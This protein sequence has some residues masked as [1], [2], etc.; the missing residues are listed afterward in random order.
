MTRTR[1]HVLTHSERQCWRNCH[2]LHGYAYVERLR[3]QRAHVALRW[4]IMFHRVVALATVAVYEELP[5]RRAMSAGERTYCV[6]SAVDW[7]R[8]Y[9][10]RTLAELR[11]ELAELGDV[12]AR[13][14]MLGELE[15]NEPWFS[16]A[17]QN[18]FEL[19]GDDWSEYELLGVEVP[20]QVRL[21]DSIGRV[22]PTMVHEG[23]MDILRVHVPT[24]RVDVSDHKTM[25]TFT[26]SERRLQL[27]D[28]TTGYL[29]AARELHR[30][31]K[32]PSFSLLAPHLTD[33]SFSSVTHNLSRKA[34]PSEP[35]VNKIKKNDQA[36]AE[37]FARLKAEEETTGHSRG[38]VSTAACDTT[39]GRY[40]AALE[41]QWTARGIPVD[42]DQRAFLRTLD[43]R[44]ETFFRRVQS[45]RS[46]H[47]LRRW[48][49]EYMVEQHHIRAARA[50]ELQ[51]TRNPGHCT[52][53][54]SASC[55]YQ[56]ICEAGEPASSRAGLV[57]GFVRVDDPHE[58]V[59]RG[60]E[61]EERR[62]REER[63]GRREALEQQRRDQAEARSAG[64]GDGERQE[65]RPRE[66]PG[67]RAP[68][69]AAQ[70]AD[71]DAGGGSG[72]GEPDGD[73]SAQADHR[74]F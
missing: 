26:N 2:A 49:S 28:Q 9:V 15:E 34:A 43:G 6:N 50:D 7:T 33:A 19:T 10:A 22:V 71:P 41:V 39:A 12:D 11:E 4:G 58:E 68:P 51:R 23:V 74:F 57:F 53:V 63:Q 18:Y 5:K 13:G 55:S 66:G 8:Y 14:D 42:D 25:A 67:D 1:L 30:A 21:R 38:R 73:G 37:V 44:G 36:D 31:G 47:D 20:F 64:G 17:A 70:E 52:G 16:H 46:D 61:E 48:C 72:R 45:V 59:R 32:L 65:V 29:F 40:R 3:P 56:S 35:R 69:E 54:A 62:E 24:L 27:D 60:S